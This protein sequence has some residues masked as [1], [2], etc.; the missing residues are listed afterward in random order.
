MKEFRSRYEANADYEGL[1]QAIEPY[2]LRRTKKLVLADRL[3]QKIENA[4]IY[5]D[6]SS[7]QRSISRSMLQTKETGQV[8]VLNMLT[9]LRQLYGHPGAIIP[10]Y[11]SLE[12]N[13]V[14]K[15]ERVI[16]ILDLVK[17]Q[18]EKALIF[19]EFRRIHSI[20]KRVLMNR[21][22]ISEYPS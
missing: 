9:K 1:L 18:G 22:G 15:L 13:E 5:I 12:L 21:Y 20:V 19:T 17:E 14:P 7:V 16:A 10:D 3:P 2:Y 6:A 11:E 4:P 8:A